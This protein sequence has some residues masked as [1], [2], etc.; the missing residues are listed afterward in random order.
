MSETMLRGGMSIPSYLAPFALVLG[1]HA[2]EEAGPTP[3]ASAES[4]MILGAEARAH[5]I[6]ELATAPDYTMS[7]DSDKECPL[8]SPFST[9][10]GF[11]KF[12]I[13]V[14]LEGTSAIEV[15]VNPFYATLYDAGGEAYTATLAGCDPGLP[16]LRLT[17]GKKTRGF[18]SFE[19]PV[20]ARRL[21]LRYGPTII[22]RSAEE[23][24]FTVVR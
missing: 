13:E 8:D 11:V 22:G 20:G 12:G 4:A 21:E 1:C 2:R 16:S 5:T 3:A 14:S 7:M 18:V 10:H 6:G 24:R 19:I 17:T 15:P 9:R 23:L